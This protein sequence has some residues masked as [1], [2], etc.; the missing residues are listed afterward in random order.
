MSKNSDNF[1]KCSN[2]NF[3]VFGFYETDIDL[4]EFQVKLNNIEKIYLY[5]CLKEY[6]E[7]KIKN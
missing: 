3:T 4:F 1:L 2:K 7:T 6:A 5:S